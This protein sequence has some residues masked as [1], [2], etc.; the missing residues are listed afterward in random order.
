M[1]NGEKMNLGAD[2]GENVGE[3]LREINRERGEMSRLAELEAREKELMAEEEK[4]LEE[5]ETLEVRDDKLANEEEE[6]MAE[7]KD[8]ENGDGEKISSEKAR[9]TLEKAKSKPGLKKLLISAGLVA[10]AALISLGGFLSSRKKGDVDPSQK[11]PGVETMDDDR[12]AA[13]GVEDKETKESEK[14]IKDGYGE[15][16]MYFVYDVTESVPII[17]LKVWLIILLIYQSNCNQKVL[18]V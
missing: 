8:L 10:L 6:L 14:G 4:L 1:P 7:L 13:G 11:Q 17:R 9:E 12:D 5:L 18:R 3:E 2:V 15:K 16:G